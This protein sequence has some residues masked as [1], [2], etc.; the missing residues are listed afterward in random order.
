MKSENAKHVKHVK[1]QHASRALKDGGRVKG[2]QQLTDGHMIQFTGVT[3]V[4]GVDVQGII[5]AQLSLLQEAPL[6]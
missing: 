4:F 3:D 1:Q 2:Q 6:R 5:R